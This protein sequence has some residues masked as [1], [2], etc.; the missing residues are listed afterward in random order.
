MIVIR[1]ILLMIL[2]MALLA[3]SDLFIKLAAQR[4]PIGQ[5]LLSLSLGGTCLYVAFSALVGQR[6]WSPDLFHPIVLLRNS[7]E[8]IAGLFLVL[9]I[10]YTPLTIFAVIVQIA[11]ILVVMGGAL[12]LKETVGW[13]RWAA[14]C[15]GLV[16]MLIVIRPWSEGFTPSVIFAIVGVSALAARDLITRLAPAQIPALALSTW[17]F[18]AT[19]PVG[20]VFMLWERAALNTEPLT[21]MH[22][23][24]AILVTTTGYFAI[25]SAMRMAPVSIVAPFRYTRLIFTTSLGLIFLGERL[26]Q[27]TLIGAVIISGAGLYTFLRER[28]LALAADRQAQSQA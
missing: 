14:V 12:F 22:I 17:G 26:D 19:I 16:G 10:A 2:S 8:M 3:L 23:A 5:V 20:L 28:R 9:G 13:R 27:A 6:L 11:P 24:L 4:A 21:L 25:T 7:F 1:A 18:A 15:T